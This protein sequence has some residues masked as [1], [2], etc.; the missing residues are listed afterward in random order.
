MPTYTHVNGEYEQKRLEEQN[1]EWTPKNASHPG[2]P[3]LALPFQR[4]LVSPV[5]GLSSL[6][7]CLPDEQDRAAAQMHRCTDAQERVR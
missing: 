2:P 5:A 3:M 1:L 4:R 6:G 7:G